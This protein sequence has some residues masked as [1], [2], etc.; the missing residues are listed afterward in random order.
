MSDLSEQE[1]FSCLT[2]NF[3][4]AVQSCEQLARNPRRGPTYAKLRT[5]LRL[6]EGAARQV[7]VWRQDARWYQIGLMMAEAHKRAGGWLRG[8]KK[9]DGTKVMLAGD[10]LHPLFLKLADNLRMGLKVSEDFRTKATGRI[11]MILPNQIPGP[12]RDTRPTGWTN[13]RGGVLIPAG[14]S[15]Q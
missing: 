7:A 6:I 11:G 2:D 13:S 4:S 14:V 1:I 3:K 9:D 12:H 8:H 5:E 15:V 10:E